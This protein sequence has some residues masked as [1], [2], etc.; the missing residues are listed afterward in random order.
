MNFAHLDLRWLSLREHNRGRRALHLRRW[1]FARLP[2]VIVKL[3]AEP[4]FGATTAISAEPCLNAARHLGGD[5]RVLVPHAR[6][7]RTGDAQLRG[8]SR[9]RQHDRGQHVF[10][11]GDTG[12]RGIVLRLNSNS[13]PSLLE[14][15]ATQ[16]DA[17]RY[18]HLN[19]PPDSMASPATAPMRTCAARSR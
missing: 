16:P 3:H 2:K 10:T 5:R 19:S 9:H 1:T 7:R 8:S 14:T 6:Q 15:F 13:R 11:Q 4:D 18:A 12:V 17:C